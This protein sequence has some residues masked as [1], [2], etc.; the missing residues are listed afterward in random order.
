MGEIKAG[1]AEI[2]KGRLGLLQRPGIGHPR[3]ER[4]RPRL[5]GTAEAYRRSFDWHPASLCSPR[6]LT[7]A[8]SPMRMSQY[9]LPTL[10]EDPSGPRSSPTG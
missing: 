7:E 8:V 2:R 1:K 10:K 9:F 5:P 6:T 3:A 4:N